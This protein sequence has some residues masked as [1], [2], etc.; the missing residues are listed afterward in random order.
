METINDYSAIFPNLYEQEIVL[1]KLGWQWGDVSNFEGL[2]FF[3]LLAKYGYSPV[4]EFGTF[5]GR[6]TYNLALNSKQKVLTIDI[7]DSLGQT[8]DMNA[9]IEKHDTQNIRPAKISCMPRT[10]SETKSSS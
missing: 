4:V 10:K 2:I 7:G 1:G 9:N 5:R 3:C 8:F 6:T